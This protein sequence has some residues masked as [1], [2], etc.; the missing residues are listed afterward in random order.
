MA[1]TKVDA[2]QTEKT[3]PFLKGEGRNRQSTIAHR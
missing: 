3:S 1:K 2:Y